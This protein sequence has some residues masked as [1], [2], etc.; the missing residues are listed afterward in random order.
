MR[1][2]SAMMSANDPALGDD[3]WWFRHRKRPKLEDNT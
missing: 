3:T 2:I 1:D